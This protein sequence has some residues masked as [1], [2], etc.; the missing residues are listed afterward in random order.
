MS[1]GDW[2][3]ASYRDTDMSSSRR[4]LRLVRP[5]AKRRSLR[6][7]APANEAPDASKTRRRA[8]A[9]RPATSAR[10]ARLEKRVSVLQREIKCQRQSIKELWRELLRATDPHQR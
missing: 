3:Y 9:K 6:P 5:S 10:V 7:A 1:L 2:I 4:V 8:L